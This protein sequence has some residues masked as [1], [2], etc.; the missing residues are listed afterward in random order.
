[1]RVRYC[2]FSRDKLVL[3]DR[4][5]LADAAEGTWSVVELFGGV[6]AL[7]QRK[8]VSVVEELHLWSS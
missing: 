5:I 6:D 3:G 7:T 8:R 1:M 2:S 4:D